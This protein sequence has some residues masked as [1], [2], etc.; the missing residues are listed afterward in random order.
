MEGL[1]LRPAAHVDTEFAFH[2]KKAALGDYVRMIYGWDEDEQR[3]LH[4]HRFRTSATCIIVFQGQEI[5]LVTRQEA[6]DHIQLLQLFLLPEA[7]GRGIGSSVLAKVLDEADRTH[8]SVA[9]RVLKSNPR[10]RAFYERHG[11]ALVG[12]T[13][14]HYELERVS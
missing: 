3:K 12:E 14:T 13:E 4:A 10:A 9:L 6:D 1:L 7:Q 8:R 11:F 2:V 5:G